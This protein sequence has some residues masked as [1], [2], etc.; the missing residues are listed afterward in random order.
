MDKLIQK[1]RENPNIRNRV[2]NFLSNEIKKQTLENARTTSIT[3]VPQKKNKNYKTRLN[4]I[5]EVLKTSFSE[6]V[7]KKIAKYLDTA[8][9]VR[10]LD[11]SPDK[12]LTGARRRPS[13]IYARRIQDIMNVVHNKDERKR[14]IVFFSNTEKYLDNKYTRKQNNN[15]NKIKQISP[16]YKKTNSEATIQEALRDS[17]ANLMKSMQKMYPGFDR[18]MNTQSRKAYNGNNQVEGAQERVI[19]GK[20]RQ[21][22]KKN[23]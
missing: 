6:E 10:R 1:L 21:R 22:Q 16:T 5:T 3:Y 20:G 18:N 23:S 11:T 7:A 15:T 17:Q 12:P 19:K 8:L 2:K 9:F 13:S 4:A 14:L